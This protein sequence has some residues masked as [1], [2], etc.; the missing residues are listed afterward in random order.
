MVTGDTFL[1]MMESTALCHVPV[2]TI[3]QS[4]GAP[5]H[6]SCPARLFL[7]GVSWPLNRKGRTH[8]LDLSFSRFYASSFLLLGI[9]VKDNVYRE[10][11]QNLKE[12]RDRT[13]RT[14]ECVT[15][16]ML[17]NTSPETEYR[18]YVCCA[19]NGAHIEIY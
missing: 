8:F 12:L 14:A 11:V 4:D 17:A 6:L 1:A 10:K 19:T 9:F 3:F 5:P 15:N 18:L 13:I 2:G 7:D 16:E